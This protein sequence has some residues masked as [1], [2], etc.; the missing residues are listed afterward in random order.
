[1]GEKDIRTIVG[2]IIRL[3]DITTLKNLGVAA[4]FQ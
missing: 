3:D 4:V 1:M 2:G